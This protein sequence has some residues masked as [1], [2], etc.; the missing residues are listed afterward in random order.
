M[1][2]AQHPVV[3]RTWTCSIIY[4]HIHEWEKGLANWVNELRRD[5]KLSLFVATS[6]RLL[7]FK[8]NNRNSIACKELGIP[9][10]HYALWPTV[11]VL[12]LQ[13]DGERAHLSHFSYIRHQQTMLCY[14]YV[15]NSP[16]N[17]FS[18]LFWNV[19]WFPFSLHV[20]R[21]LINKILNVNSYPTILNICMHKSI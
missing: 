10:M 14:I 8:I 9:K 12:V 4:K 1:I 3:F 21:Q 19:Y 11:R 6:M 5:E 7:F 16:C 20:T 15:S 13:S 18:T 2:I 17:V